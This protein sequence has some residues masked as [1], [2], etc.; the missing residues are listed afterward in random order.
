MS[1]VY[2]TLVELEEKGE[3]LDCQT[4]EKKNHVA[5]ESLESL[6]THRMNNMEIDK[7]SSPKSEGLRSQKIQTDSESKYS[8]VPEEAPDS[9]AQDVRSTMTPE[10]KRDPTNGENLESTLLTSHSSPP[11]ANRPRSSSLVTKTRFHDYVADEV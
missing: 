11:K 7:F 10:L 9:N 1:N 4:T 8:S 6:E 3:A 5:G 2:K